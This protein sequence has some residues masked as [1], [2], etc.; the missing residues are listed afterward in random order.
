MDVLHSYGRKAIGEVLSTCQNRFTMF[1]DD[2][3]QPRVLGNSEH[4]NW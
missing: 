2:N 3:K 4:S 1:I